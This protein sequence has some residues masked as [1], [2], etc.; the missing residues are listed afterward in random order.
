MKMNNSFIGVAIGAVLFGYAWHKI[1]EHRKEGV[2]MARNVTNNVGN[3]KVV[4]TTHK[5]TR[6]PRVKITKQMVKEWRSMAQRGITRAEIAK[7]YNVSLASVNKHL[8]SVKKKAIAET[9][10][11][12]NK[13]KI[14]K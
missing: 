12:N 1:K 9:E 8:A 4:D 3:F 5:S 2:T 11:N 6:K 13:F 10:M 14:N 7:V